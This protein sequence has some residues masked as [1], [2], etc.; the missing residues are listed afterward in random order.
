MANYRPISVLPFFAKIFEKLMF[1][2]LSNFLDKANII[3]PSQ[4]G[5]QAGRSPSMPLL[6]IQDE[7]SEAIE[8]NDY[9]I[10]VFFDLVKAFD[11][12]NH[13]ILLEKLNNYGI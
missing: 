5:F 13:N 2:R 7:I 11:T 9:S 12:V 1:E 4:H 3:F 8:N 6:S 10:K